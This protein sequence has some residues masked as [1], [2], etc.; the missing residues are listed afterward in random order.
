MNYYFLSEAALFFSS[1]NIVYW[2]SVKNV[3]NL[4][5]LGGVS[6]VY[7]CKHLYKHKE[8]VAMWGPFR[9]IS[10]KREGK[11]KNARTLN[12]Y[13]N[14]V[15]GPAKN[16]Y[17]PKRKKKVLFLALSLKSFEEIRPSGWCC[18]IRCWSVFVSAVDCMS[19]DQAIEHAV[20]IPK[21]TYS[22][23]PLKVIGLSHLTLFNFLNTIDVK[24]INDTEYIT[25]DTTELFAHFVYAV[26]LL[27]GS[28]HQ[29]AISHLNSLQDRVYTE[30]SGH[31]TSR[32]VHEFV[33]YSAHRQACYRWV[34]NHVK[35]PCLNYFVRPVPEK[36]DFFHFQNE[37]SRFACGPQSVF[38]MVEKTFWIHF[39]LTDAGINVHI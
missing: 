2:E 14:Q 31:L 36:Y 8:A 6:F 22:L 39:F 29:G 1:R 9:F 5:I 35:V 33:A 16:S 30:P 4:D 32:A 21:R 13:A 34:R 7:V 27:L 24:L 20:T 18:M 26:G 38:L 19:S 23:A 17:A 11:G 10:H 37:A 25:F 12:R 15:R 28:L 3:E